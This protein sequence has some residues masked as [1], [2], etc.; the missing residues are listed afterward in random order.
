M[1]PRSTALQ[2]ENAAGNLEQPQM[3]ASAHAAE[4]LVHDAVFFCD[5]YS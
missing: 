4:E 3:C 2:G 1:A 5:I